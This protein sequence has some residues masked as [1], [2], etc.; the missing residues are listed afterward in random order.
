MRAL[1]TVVAGCSGAAPAE[2]TTP[3]PPVAST[4]EISI[5]VDGETHTLSAS[6]GGLDA[7]GTSEVYWFQALGPVEGD[8]VALSFY[9]RASPIAAADY[10]LGGWEGTQAEGSL[11]VFTIDEVDST[12]TWTYTA[13]GAT[14]VTDGVLTVAELDRDGDRVSLDWAGTF[15]R[16]VQQDGGPL[17]D[18]GVAALTGS[19]DGLRWSW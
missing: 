5:D 4:G 1:I 2:L 12:T 3:L 16:Q 8:A 14:A 7:T 11:I 15:Q 9:T 18:D 19:A 10:P 6:G 17:V 13:G